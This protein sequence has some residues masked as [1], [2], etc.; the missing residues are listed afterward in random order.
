M[1]ARSTIDVQ[2]VNKMRRKMRRPSHTFYLEQIPFTIQ[3]FLLAPVLPGETLEHAF[4][5]SRVV[6][7][8]VSN[9]IIGWW[10]EY[11]LFYV[12]HRDLDDRDTLSG[13]M[14]D[15]T[16]TSSSLLD[17]DDEVINYFNPGTNSELN[18]ATRCLKRVTEEYFRSESEAWD[19]VTIGGLPVCSVIGN[20]LL[21]SFMNDDDYQTSIEP[22]ID[23]SG[24]NVGIT[25]IMAAEREWKLL[26]AANMSEMTY[27]DYL[28]TYGVGI[29]QA[30]EAHRPELLRFVREWQYPSN[31]IDPSTGAP[32]SAVSW[33]VSDRVDK[34]RFFKEPGFVFGVSCIRP[35]IYLGNQASAGVTALDT[36]QSWLPAL[37]SDD[38]N[39]SLMQ[40]TAGTGP[41]PSNTDDY[42][43]DMKDL[44]LFGDQFKNLATAGNQLALPTAGGVWKYPTNQAML[45]NLFVSAN[46]TVKTDGIMS[47]H[48]AG[49][50]SNTT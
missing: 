33:A 15:P 48:V 42:W 26:Q 37:L 39:T 18:W 43:L 7:D 21:D 9:P 17:S 27:E 13:M 30:E 3:P 2:T 6:T 36:A 46:A 44:F 11:Y 14:I 40:F 10:C 4:I 12:K 5:Q 8:P 16:V 28:R 19:N 34:K 24:S 23:T 45:D 41:Y 49:R 38:P 29:P 32:S 35:K 22:T 31:T 50:L 1:A 20:S 47:L 25:E